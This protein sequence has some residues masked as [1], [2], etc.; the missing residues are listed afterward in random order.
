MKKVAP[1]SPEDKS[2]QISKGYKVHGIIKRA[3]TFNMTRIGHIYVEP[4]TNGG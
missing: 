2:H 1:V 4:Q 3:S